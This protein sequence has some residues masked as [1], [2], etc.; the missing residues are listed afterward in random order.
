M[1]ETNGAGQGPVPAAICL[2]SSSERAA[3]AAKSNANLAA[4]QQSRISPGR[5]V[6]K[7][8]K[9]PQTIK[10]QQWK[11]QGA[12]QARTE[13]GPAWALSPKPAAAMSWRW[14]EHRM[15]PIRPMADRIWRHARWRP[16]WQAPGAAPLMTWC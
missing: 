4:L 6:R 15:P 10:G 11:A 1:E 12:G 5:F 14:T 9:K 16:C 3:H 2:G 8:A 13:P 7:Q